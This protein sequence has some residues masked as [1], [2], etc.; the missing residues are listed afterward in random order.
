M[1][2]A[3]QR[4]GD[5]T[6]SRSIRD[7]LTNAPFPNNIIPASRLSPASLNYMKEF[8]PLPNAANNFYTFPNEQST[9][10]DQIVAKIDHLI[11]ANNHFSGRLL[12]ERNNNNQVPNVDDLP[13]FWAIIAYKNWNVSVNDIHTFTPRLINQFTFGYNNITR[14][15]F[16]HVA[17]EKSWKDFGAGFV[18]SAPGPIAY[19]TQVSGNFRTF[20]R[21]LL[22]QYR[23]YLQFSDG[24]NWT[25]GAHTLKIGGE[26]RK[27]ICDQSQKFQTDPQVI[28]TTNYT[29]FALADFLIGR[30]N[31]FTQGSPNGGKPN[32]FEI[33]A[34]IQDDWKVAPR[35]TMNVGLRWDP[36]QP[37]SDDA[38][39][40]SQFRP[41]QQS[42]VY[43]T[44]P[45]GTVFPGDDGV[46]NTTLQPRMNNW[47][48]R[49][50]FAYDVFGTNKT[51]LRAGYGLFYS[52]VRQ[53][54]LNNI[55]SNEPFGISMAVP[56]PS[57]GLANPYADSGNPFPFTPPSSAQ[58]RQTFKFILPMTTLTQWDP[59]FRN[60]IV[61]QFNVSVQQ[62][63]LSDW[64]VTVA[65]AGTTGNHL[66][67]TNQLNP[68][69]YGKPGANASARRIYAPTYT[70]IVSMMSVGNSNYHGLQVT[71]NKRFHRGLTILM[72]YTWSKSI[73]QGSNDG[74]TPAN[75][76]NIRNE[77]GP[78]EFNLPHKFTG[79]FV[80]QLPGGTMHNAAARHLA[81]GWELNGIINLQSGGPFT[82]TSGIDNSQ[83][84]VG[85]DRA[86]VV[87]DWRIS[88]DQ[89]KA[90]ML[91]Q[92][93]NT[94][95]FAVNTVGT[96]GNAGRNILMGPGQAN[97]DFGAIKTVTIKDRYKVQFRAEAFNTF[98]HANFN[99]PNASV[100]AATFGTINSAGAP[101]V[102]QL[103]LK[104]MF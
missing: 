104:A 54:S 38:H 65:Y 50:G 57:G 33:A 56:Q 39:S 96:F 88:V 22:N 49:L 5:F 60:A 45:R 30:P 100:S 3:A 41:G 74:S 28:F 20:S 81:G 62:Q 68:A 72:N 34:Y 71:A 98:N 7:P 67:I 18:R 13:G 21:Y 23:K 11:S 77:R 52:D 37:Y 80:W 91:R 32:T 102:L 82:V 4:T 25:L 75:P 92:Y 101:R 63:I 12:W 16:P 94:A 31:S 15:Q 42:T 84:A 53:Q 90:Q 58:E 27:S 55:S 19:D 6:G 51:S 87:G 89:T 29:G 43:P 10:D 73:D 61:Q 86:N 79:S 40:I 103:A 83:S 2:S 36:W 70:S 93:F 24:L 44:A 97:F 47:G 35:L 85:A 59:N 9:V 26:I 8:V 14:E 17:A 64:I 48:P 1:L 76:Y 66:F 46:S 99:N 78:S 69:V 95:A